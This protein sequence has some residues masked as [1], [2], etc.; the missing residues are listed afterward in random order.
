[1]SKW[2][3]EIVH[4]VGKNKKTIPKTN[5]KVSFLSNVKNTNK[6][7]FPDADDEALVEV[8]DIVIS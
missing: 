2:K 3:K 5:F 1:L 7:V 6:F 8:S 4:C